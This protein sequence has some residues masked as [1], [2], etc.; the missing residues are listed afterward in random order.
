[1]EINL[2]VNTGYFFKRKENKESKTTH[3]LKNKILVIT[4][5]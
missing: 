4:S 3:D 2:S 1:M 5:I